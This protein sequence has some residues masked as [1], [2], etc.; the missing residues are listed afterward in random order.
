[1]EDYWQDGFNEGYGRADSNE[2]HDSP[3]TDCDNFSFQLGKETGERHR[4]VADDLDRE[5]YGNGY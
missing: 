5:M 4:K 1:M 3:Q 2:H